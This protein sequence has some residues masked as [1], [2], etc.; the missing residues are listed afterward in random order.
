MTIK[1]IYYFRGPSSSWKKLLV[2]DMSAQADNQSGTVWW[3]VICGQSLDHQGL[4]RKVWHSNK[5][6]FL[7][8]LKTMC[9]SFIHNIL[10]PDA[11]YT[12]CFVI[13]KLLQKM[14]NFASHTRFKKKQMTMWYKVFVNIPA[15]VY[16]F[17]NSALLL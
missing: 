9:F 10:I 4:S 16:S 17:L 13:N 7:E 12:Y 1:S 14:Q 6:T 3:F 15:I 2:Y 8:G 11:C 5:I